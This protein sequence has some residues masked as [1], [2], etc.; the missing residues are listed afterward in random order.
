MDHRQD[1]ALVTNALGMA[2]TNRNPDVGREVVI[3]SDHGTQF[4]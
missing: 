2:I 4:T 3:R 1:S